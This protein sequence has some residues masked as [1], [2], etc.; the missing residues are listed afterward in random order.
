MPRAKKTTEEV[1]TTA[2]KTETKAVAKKTAAKSTTRKA[3]VKTD[4][5]SEFNG[6]QVSLKE[7]EENVKATYAAA[8]GK[9]AIKTLKVYI[10]PDENAAYYV[11]NDDFTDKMDVFFCQ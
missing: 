7:I 11:V 6:C 5:F 1:K 8:N 10:K 9:A 3:A 4:M 2:A